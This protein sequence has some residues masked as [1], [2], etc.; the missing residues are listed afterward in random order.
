MNPPALHL[1]SVLS[2]V[3]P[4]R[5][6]AIEG[7]L[8]PDFLADLEVIMAP[9]PSADA[10]ANVLCIRDN[11]VLADARESPATLDA[12]DEAGVRVRTLDLSEFG[13]G[14]GGP[15]CLVLPLRRG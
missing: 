7:T 6:V 5:V 4:G 11:D 2:P 10:T 15:T 14:S 1:G 3:G 8:P 9:R 13:K 12:L